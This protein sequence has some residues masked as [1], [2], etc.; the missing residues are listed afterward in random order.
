MTANGNFKRRVRAR[1]AKTGE[2][3]TT[4]LRH[5][6][7][8]ATGD[9]VMPETNQASADRHVRMAVAQNTAYQGAGDSTELRA[10][11]REVRLLMREARQAGARIIHFPE[12]AT[13][14]PHKLALSTE[15]PDTVG[16]AD[17]DR[18]DWRVLEDELERTARLADE[19]GLWTVLGS[20]HRLTAPNRPH[21]SLYVISDGGVVVTRYDERM[22]SHTKIS[23]MY[24]PGSAPRT[25]EVDGVRFGCLLGMEA[26]FPELFGAYEQLDVD[27]VL[28]STA[29][30]APYDGVFATEARGHAATNSFW[31]SF[32]VPAQH[33]G[34]TPSGVIGPGGQ[35]LTRCAGDGTPSVA[36][37]DLDTSTK[38]VETAAT[39]ARPWRRTARAGL[40]EP[41]VVHDPRSNELSAF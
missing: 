31:V 12:G 8:T 21:N 39:K 1:A 7:S 18:F 13:C 30:A 2:S 33:S 9:G 5:F 25:F 28:F 35:W 24:A 16:P 37:V 6:R 17:W 14:S 23:Y 40:Y 4:A 15:G 41:H 36:V 38:D 3:Y 34:T 29:G 32:S 20:V 26:H 11:G 22:L 19:L 27:C 10:A